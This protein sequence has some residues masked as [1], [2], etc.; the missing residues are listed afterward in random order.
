MSV[1]VSVLLRH[2]RVKNTQKKCKTST[3]P[4][5]LQ[6]E[7]HQTVCTCASRYYNYCSRTKMYSQ[8]EESEG[9][10]VQLIEQ[11]FCPFY[12]SS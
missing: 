4:L 12:T 11:V 8:E 6:R 3:S 2:R 10:K 1:K 9:K 7:K 5:F